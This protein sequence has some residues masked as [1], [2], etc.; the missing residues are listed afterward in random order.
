[1]AEAPAAAATRTYGQIVDQVVASRAAVAAAAPSLV[2]VLVLVCEAARRAGRLR[3]VPGW[4][5][6]LRAG[7]RCAGRP[8]A[9][10]RVPRFAA[11]HRPPSLPC[12][13]S[14]VASLRRGRLGR[15]GARF[16][17]WRETGLGFAPPAPVMNWPQA[18][19]GL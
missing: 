15:K 7:L 5:V 11:M 19:A 6:P 13:R 3:A 9:G 8:C 18:P 1:M 16:A 17:R 2:L 10:R 4:A 12:V 14:A